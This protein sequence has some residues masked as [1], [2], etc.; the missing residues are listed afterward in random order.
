MKLIGIAESPRAPRGPTACQ[1]NNGSFLT[2]SLSKHVISDL[3]SSLYS[4]P[5]PFL[6][7]FDQIEPSDLPAV[8]G[9]ELSLGLLTR[10][11]LP[12]LRQR[13]EVDDEGKLRPQIVDQ[14][15]VGGHEFAALSLGQ[16]DVEA[17]V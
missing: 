16:G 11:G 10:A 15:V 17:V 13:G 7:T 4:T 12:R 9:N 14:L 1:R 8:G 6:R 3:A 2:Q 5:M